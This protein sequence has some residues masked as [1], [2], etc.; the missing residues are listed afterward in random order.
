MIAFGDVGWS[1][2]LVAFKVVSKSLLFLMVCN[3]RMACTNAL[4]LLDQLT[5]PSANLL[6]IYS[7]TCTWRLY[8]QYG[9]RDLVSRRTVNG[10]WVVRGGRNSKHE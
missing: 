7:A 10:D 3:A 4:V 8:G 5:G 1:E 2:R 6:R 9:R